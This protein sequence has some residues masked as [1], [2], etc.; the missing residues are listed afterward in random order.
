MCRDQPGG[1]TRQ[2]AA[3]AREPQWR[4]S[5]GARS[6]CGPTAP[7][8]DVSAHRSL[9]ADQ[10]RALPSGVSLLCMARHASRRIAR[11]VGARASG[12]RAKPAGEAAARSGRAR[13][14]RK[15]DE[16]GAA[17]AP[18]HVRHE[19]R[20]KREA[21]AVPRVLP[22]PREALLERRVA[23][24]RV[25][26]VPERVGVEGRRLVGFR[27]R[28]WLHAPRRLQGPISAAG[29]RPALLR[30]S[31]PPRQPRRRQGALR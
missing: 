8:A 21:V 27:A 16:S 20:R 11:S 30:I 17:A 13:G 24:H 26:E 4:R 2:R 19:L 1:A 22:V 28:G 3:E 7:I 6:G 31:V 25:G 9:A 18:L 10:L 5:L 14:V 29:T 12:A 15:T 23:R